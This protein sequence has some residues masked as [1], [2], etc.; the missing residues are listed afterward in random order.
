MA[1]PLP[2]ACPKGQYTKIATNVVTG[3][4]W[5]IIS[6]ARYYQTFRK[7]GEA[8]PTLF[9]EAV[10]MFQGTEKIAESIMSNEAI[11]I[12]V[13]CKIRAGSVRVDL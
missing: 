4:V 12:Y 13:W 10:P 3:Q 8:A 5:K 7:T 2:V 11:D 9:S 1:N 6:T